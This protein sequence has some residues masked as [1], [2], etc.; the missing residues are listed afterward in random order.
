MALK[1]IWTGESFATKRPAADEGPFSCVPAEM[2]PQVGCLAVDLPTSGDM[3]NVLFLF[4]W[5]T[6]FSILAEGAGTGFSP[7]TSSLGGRA[8]ILIVNGCAIIQT[9]PAC[10]QCL[11]SSCAGDGDGKTLHLQPWATEWVEIYGL[12]AWDL[13]G[14]DSCSRSLS[15]A[16]LRERLHWGQCDLCSWTLDLN[17]LPAH[18]AIGPNSAQQEGACVWHNL[19]ILKPF[20]AESWSSKYLTACGR[21]STGLYGLE[22]CSTLNDLLRLDKDLLRLLSVS[23]VWLYWDTQRRCCVLL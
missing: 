7:V 17:G 20:L 15:L 14:V 13:H 8:Y 1:L 18:L 9:F 2:G 3:T 22:G 6:S 16:Q 11:L 19:K 5:V 12:E 4:S 10:L 23:I 21:D